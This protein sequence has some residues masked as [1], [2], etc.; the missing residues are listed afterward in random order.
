MVTER[1]ILNVT[2]EGKHVA[3]FAGLSSDSKP[4][5]CANGSKFIEM[6]TGLE[7]YYD[8]ENETWEQFPP[9]AEA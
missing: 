9:A 1:L 6:D 2:D 8:E 4:T 3:E 7:Y 5:D